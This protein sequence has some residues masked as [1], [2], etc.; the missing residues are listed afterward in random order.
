MDFRVPLIN[1]STIYSDGLRPRPVYHYDAK[2][3]RPRR[4]FAVRLPQHLLNRLNRYTLVKKLFTDRAVSAAIAHERR[5]V[6]SNYFESIRNLH[7]GRRGFVICNGPSL[8]MAD[9]SCLKNEISIASNRIYLAF[10]EMDWR[11]SY[12]TIID[13]LVWQ[14]IAGQAHNCYSSLIIPLAL[15]PTLTHCVTYQF[16]DLGHAPFI[17]DRI[18]FSGDLVQGVYGGS[19]VTYTNLQIAH[20]LGLNPVYLIGCDHFY[21]EPKDVVERQPVEHQICNHFSE[22]YREKGEMV[23]PAPIENMTKS[24][25]AAQRYCQGSDFRIYN[26]TRGGHLE[27][28]PRCSF[29]S[30]IHRDS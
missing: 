18:P 5:R 15:N 3:V 22:K 11:P 23:N 10:D 14:K 7:A 28:F 27:V 17:A 19:S 2:K 24:F 9:L 8:S 12:V 6:S 30:L 29:D 4:G 21:N 13:D 25:E 26:A 20:H 1:E 16:V